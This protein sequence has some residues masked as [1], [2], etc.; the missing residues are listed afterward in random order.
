MYKIFIVLIK[1][2][3]FVNLFMVVLRN[4]KICFLDLENK[5]NYFERIKGVICII[6]LNLYIKYY[7]SFKIF[8]FIILFRLFFEVLKIREN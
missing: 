6:I 5:R 3:I 8:I 4:K 1:I 7:S 2:D